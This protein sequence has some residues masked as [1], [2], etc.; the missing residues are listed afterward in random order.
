MQK[1]AQKEQIAILERKMKT[2]EDI[3]NYCLKWK[4]TDPIY[5]A[6]VSRKFGM[7]KRTI[8]K[9][10]AIINRIQK[11]PKLRAQIV[12]TKKTMILMESDEK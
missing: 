6:E 12:E 4:R 9:I 7:D 5:L 2:Y 11:M 8:K 10:F 1:D 3:I